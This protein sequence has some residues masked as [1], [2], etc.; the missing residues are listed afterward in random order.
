MHPFKRSARVSDLIREEVADI[1]M[2]RIKHKELGFI[3]VTGAKVSDDLRNATIYI[4]V[5]NLEDAEKTIRKLNESKSF[6]KTELA[7]RLTMKYIPKIS[8]KI[9]EAIEYGRK[10]DKL[11]DDIKEERSDF[12]KD[13]DLF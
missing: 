1:I 13:E 6:I 2:N 3:T 12:D 4:S 9:D 8:F 5:L 11:L 10:I 7:G